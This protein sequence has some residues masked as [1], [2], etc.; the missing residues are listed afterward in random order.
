MKPEDCPKLN[1]CP[2]ISMVLDKDLASDWQYA[3]V[4]REICAKWDGPEK[5]L[6]IPPPVWRLSRN[7]ASG[8]P[9]SSLGIDADGKGQG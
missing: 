3:Q 9:L 2:K 5:G 7:R 4:I 1:E 6:G 8:I